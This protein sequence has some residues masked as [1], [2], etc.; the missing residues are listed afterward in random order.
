MIA[1]LNHSR[2]PAYYFLI[3]RAAPVVVVNNPAGLQMR[4]DRHCTHILEAAFLQ[5]FTDPVGQT[6]ADRDHPDIVSLIQNR[7]S[8][9]VGPNVIAKAAVLFAHLP[10][11]PG[12][13]DHRLDLA[14]RTDHALRIQDTLNICVVV[15]SDLVIVEIVEALPEDFTLLQH[16]IP[17]QAALQAFQ[18]QVLEHVSVVMYRDSPFGIMVDS[19]G[20]V[21]P[22]PSAVS[23]YDSSAS[24]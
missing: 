13:V 5:V 14:R 16:Q 10:V 24:S 1:P 11:A 15:E 3:A 7:F 22:G 18:R 20:L 17:A 2:K 9:G 4:T 6:I 23:H 21:H 19:V 12:I 8:A